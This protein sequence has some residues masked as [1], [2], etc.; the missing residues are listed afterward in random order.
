MSDPAI[1][2][3]ELRTKRGCSSPALHQL[4][5]ERDRERDGAWLKAHSS[6]GLRDSTR[7]QRG[8]LTRKLR[9]GAVKWACLHLN[10]AQLLGLEA[11]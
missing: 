5:L 2:W 1:A 9:T 8:P 6:Q 4:A 7:Q 10:P 3:E 11:V